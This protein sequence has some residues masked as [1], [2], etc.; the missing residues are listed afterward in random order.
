MPLIKNSTYKAPFLLRNAHTNTV[1]AALVRKVP[2]VF[3][4][5]EVLDTPDGDFLDL[6]WSFV[7]SDKL[8]IVLHGLEG[9]ADRPYMLGMIREFNR[10]GWDGLGFNFR[11][12][13][14]RLNRKAASYHMGWTQDLEFVIEHI[15]NLDKYRE[16]VLVGFSLGGNV[17]LNYL[18]RKGSAVPKLVKKP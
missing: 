16:V 2:G 11:G 13:S 15:L 5:R 18:G 10:S 1:Y 14:G 4:E 9:S 17:I 3:Y 6:D 12:C 7:K 8:V